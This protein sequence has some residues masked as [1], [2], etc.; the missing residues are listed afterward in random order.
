MA[1][2][3][4]TA[5]LDAVVP[6]NI[7]PEEY[8]KQQEKLFRESQL[9][10]AAAAASAAGYDVKITGGGAVVTGVRKGGP[11]AR[12]LRNNDVIVAVDGKRVRTVED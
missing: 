5:P 8:F 2:G 9:V 10:A 12:S 4:D 7:D 6:R 3:K 11:A 1:E